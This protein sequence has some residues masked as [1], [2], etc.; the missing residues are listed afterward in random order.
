MLY[1]Q[2]LKIQ[3]ACVLNKGYYIH[4]L[5]SIFR[6]LFLR[7]QLLIFEL[8]CLVH[9]ILNDLQNPRIVKIADQYIDLSFLKN[10]YFRFQN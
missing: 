6:L 8:L 5:Q 10:Y 7:L 2:Y 3:L 1:H 9:R 4:C